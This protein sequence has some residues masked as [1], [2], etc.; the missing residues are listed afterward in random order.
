M[1][2][3]I[4][5]QD[6]VIVYSNT[7]PTGTVDFTIRGNLNVDTINGS[8]Y[9]PLTGLPGS[10]PNII[11]DS[12]RSL[13]LLK[14][15]NEYIHDLGILDTA[16]TQDLDISV[17]SNFCCILATDVTFNFIGA[18]YFEPPV[19]SMVQTITIYVQQDSVGNRI[20]TW[21]IGIYWEGGVVPSAS[22]EA[23]ALDIYTFITYTGGTVW[24]GF[25]K[26]KRLLSSI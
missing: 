12:S 26:A 22:T 16:F 6:G 9:P 25:Q 13:L 17:S 1:S 23:G 10:I 8:V 11:W 20:P 24:L 15:H 21:P 7:D 14:S 2:Q 18:Q 5:V 19:K 4:K 3:K